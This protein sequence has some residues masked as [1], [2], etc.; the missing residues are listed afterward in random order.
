[1]VEKVLVCIGSAFHLMM[2]A[3]TST[4][5]VVDKYT[6]VLC[7]TRGKFFI[8]L[9]S[10]FNPKFQNLLWRKTLKTKICNF[11]NNRF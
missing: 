8:L 7:G 4:Y 3:I 9:V 10:P 1:M 6:K 2:L 5:L 11:L